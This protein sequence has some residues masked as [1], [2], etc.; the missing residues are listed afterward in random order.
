AIRLREVQPD[1][2]HPDMLQTPQPAGAAVAKWKRCCLVLACV[3]PLSGHAAVSMLQ[4]PRV[5]DGAQPLTLTLLI[6][7]EAGSRRH[8]VPDGVEV[9]ASGDLQAPVKL[10]LRRVDPGPAILSLRKG[11][12]RTIRYA[13]DLPPGLRGTIRLDAT[14]I[15]A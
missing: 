2:A 1:K 8:E 14:G 7:A 4:P 5:I 15:D 13:A 10:S 12:N 3:W 9:T 11:E 6:S